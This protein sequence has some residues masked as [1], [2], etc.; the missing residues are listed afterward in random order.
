MVLAIVAKE[1]SNLEK[2]FRRTGKIDANLIDDAAPNGKRKERLSVPFKRSEVSTPDIVDAYAELLRKKRAEER[3]YRE[4]YDD[5][6]VDAERKVRFDDPGSTRTRKVVEID[7]EDPF[8]GSERKPKQA[9][10]RRVLEM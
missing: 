6:D 9:K 1:L 2:E 7:D 5:P 10:D 4:M 8:N 3:M